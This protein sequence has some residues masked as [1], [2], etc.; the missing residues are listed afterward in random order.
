MGRRIAVLRPE[1]SLGGVQAV[2]WDGRDE[3]GSLVPSGLY[4]LAVAGR[5]GTRST[6]FVVMR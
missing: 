5:D 3:R 2:V 6:K 4:V 1:C